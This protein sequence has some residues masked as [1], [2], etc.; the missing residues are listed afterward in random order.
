VS[1]L[2]DYVACGWLS[3]GETGAV[4]IIKAHKK[5]QGAAVLWCIFH[6]SVHDAQKALIEVKVA[7]HQLVLPPLSVMFVCSCSCCC[8]TKQGTF[9]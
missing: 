8:P 2:S 7:C 3:P 5:L 9:R 6:V 1:T 4:L